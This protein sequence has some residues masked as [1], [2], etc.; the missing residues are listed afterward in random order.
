LCGL[1]A[2]VNDAEEDGEKS[3]HADTPLHRYVPLR[4]RRNIRFFLPLMVNVEVLVSYQLSTRSGGRPRHR[5]M[6]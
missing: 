3:P 5:E 1:Q 4:I 6:Q 2:V